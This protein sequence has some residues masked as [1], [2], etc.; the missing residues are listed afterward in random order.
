MI[1]LSISK[2]FRIVCAIVA[3]TTIAPS[4]YADPSGKLVVSTIHPVPPVQP[5][6]TPAKLKP[7]LV[8]IVNVSATT[9]VV[10]P[11]INPTK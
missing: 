9:P 10:Q 2:F 1:K 7:V 8:P 6:A 4:T 3:V 11:P 5:P